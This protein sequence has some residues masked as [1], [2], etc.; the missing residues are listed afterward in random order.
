VRGIVRTAEPADRLRR[1]GRLSLDFDTL[2]LDGTRL[3]LR[4]RIVS[5]QDE[6]GS[7]ETARKAG[8][9]AIIGGAVGGL[10]KGRTG[11]L[12]GVLAG[13]GIVMA[14]RGEDVEIPEG[15][16]LRVRLDRAIAVPRGLASAD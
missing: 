13:S 16:I 3:D 5:L 11:A 8:I 10:L 12:V 6:S 2:Y 4:T 15:T 7:K 1:A 14:Q 9:G